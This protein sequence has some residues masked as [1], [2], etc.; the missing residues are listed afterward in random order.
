[1]IPAAA[2]L[3]LPAILGA[4]LLFAVVPVLPGGRAAGLWR[5]SAGL[6]LGAAMASALTFIWLELR[7]GLG[8]ALM[9]VELSA[10]AGLALAAWRASATGASRGGGA[11]PA[12]PGGRGLLLGAAA[13]AAA[14]FGAA[15]F[16]VRTLSEP[17]GFWDAWAIWNLRARF[18]LRAGHEWRRAFSAG[19][20]ESHPDYPLNLPCLVARGWLYAGTETRWVPVLT[21]AMFTLATA[22]LLAASLALMRGNRPA[23]AAWAVLLSTPVFVLNGASQCADV[24]LGFYFLGALACLALEGR[25]PEA[26]GRLAAVSGMMAGCAAWTKNE[27]ILLAACLAAARLWTASGGRG[28]AARARLWRFALG[29]MPAALLLAFFRLTLATPTDLLAGQS[30]GL[31]AASLA[32]PGRYLAVLRSF[33]RLA[34]REY[35]PA[36]ATAFAAVWL[37]KA[38]RREGGRSLAAGPAAVLAMVAAGYGMVYVLTPKPLAWHLSTSLSRVAVQLWPAALLCAFLVAG[39]EGPPEKTGASPG[40]SS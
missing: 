31:I 26:A 13:L 28:P 14:G 18:L 16:A 6:G 30:W 23:A 15:A 19:L 24:P 38:R 10:A 25:F 3:I 37:L 33:L 11:P 5:W 40:L 4:L 35:G 2:S 22:A 8:R 21:A 1:M 9:A 12:A 34:V 7:G 20:L 36:A 27:G 39:R 32:D 17:H 29:M